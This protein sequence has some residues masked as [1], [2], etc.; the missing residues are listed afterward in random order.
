MTV[1]SAGLPRAALA[2]AFASLAC[3]ASACTGRGTS[4]DVIGIG[5][6]A[7]IKRGTT[8]T[9]ER[10]V[11]VAVDQLNAEGHG[12]RF[13]LIP[14]PRAATAAVEIAV[15]LRD[16]PRVVAVVGHTD[17]KGSLDSAPV[18]GDEGGTR[19]LAAISPTSTSTALTGYSR[20]VFRVCPSDAAVS[21]KVA[22]YVLDSL[23]VH[24]ATIMY[25]N[26][27]YGKG[28]AANFAGAF[29]TGGGTIVEKDPHL[30]DMPEWDA[31]VGMVKKTRP[32]LILFPGSPADAS[33]FIAALR[34]A[35][36]EVPVLGG[37]AISELAARPKEFAGLR[38]V[39]FFQ[40]SRAETSAP[41]RVFVEA[42]QRKYGTVPDQR[43]ALAYD[44]TMVIGRA[45]LAVGNDRT[46]VR[47][48]IASIQGERAMEGATGRIA[49][50]DKNDVVD[51][52]VVVAT[53]GR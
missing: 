50:D 33:N 48:Y 43:S 1:R 7:D 22:R 26:D 3:L 34:A 16:D 6:A 27:S 24:R 39:A 12:V 15:A 17:S 9:V 52:Q 36:A 10:G 51:K 32:E 20:W 19:A 53:V 49:F 23:G 13:Q 40:A 31:Y 14:P 4:G 11:Q 5:L 35:G 41:A 25:R 29:R 30:T 18:Y 47:D 38:Y 28:W 2:V 37:D 44:A 21:R 42:F 8:A 46:K 45:A